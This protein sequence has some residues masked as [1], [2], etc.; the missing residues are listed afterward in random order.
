MIT[1]EDQIKEVQ[2]ELA[3]RE[4]LYPGWVLQQKLTEGQAAYR[5]AALRA[6]L[7]T[8]EETNQPELFPRT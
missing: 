7:Q 2:R 1:L 6:V 8:L 3:Q 5:L 4:R